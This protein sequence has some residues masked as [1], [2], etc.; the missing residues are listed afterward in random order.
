MIIFS[1][2]LGLS[3]AILLLYVISFEAI[4]L[5]VLLIT[6][7][8]VAASREDLNE[9]RT[10]RNLIMIIIG[11]VVV[12]FLSAAYF[13]TPYSLILFYELVTL[14]AALLIVYVAMRLL[15]TRRNRSG[16]RFYNQQSKWRARM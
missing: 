16:A 3:F 8:I 10:D 12:V 7:S 6:A 11:S 14:N 15:V 2:N 5:V 4:G 13:S 9:L 1:L